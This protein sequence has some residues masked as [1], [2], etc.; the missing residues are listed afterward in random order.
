MAKPDAMGVEIL[1]RLAAD[2]ERLGRF[3][4]LTGLRADTLRDV[5]GR[6]EFWVALF[7]YVVSDEPLLLEIAREINEPP[8]RI[9]AAQ[10]RLSPPGFLE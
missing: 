10:R 1:N 5:A 3:I 2:P 9:A 8:E 4:D 6:P 7:E